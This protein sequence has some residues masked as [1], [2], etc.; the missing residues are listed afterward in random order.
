MKATIIFIG[1]SHANFASATPM[2]RGL[3]AEKTLP[4]LHAANIG[5]EVE[6]IHHASPGATTLNLAHQTN[7]ALAAGGTSKYIFISVGSNDLRS[8]I[9]KTSSVEQRK[10]K[11]ETALRKI[12]TTMEWLAEHDA[13]RLIHLFALWPMKSGRCPDAQVREFNHLTEKFNNRLQR[14]IDDINQKMGRVA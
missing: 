13:T 2:F 6:Y 4:A 5:F 9:A 3:R 11:I 1:D 10:V 7:M 12:C 8:A 14:K